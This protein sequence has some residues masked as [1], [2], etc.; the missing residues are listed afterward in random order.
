MKKSSKDVRIVRDLAKQV[1][2]IAGSPEMEASRKR[3]RDVNAL[4]RPDR[5][6]VW[7]KPVGAWKEL[8]P[9]TDLLCTDRGLRGIERAFR[10]VLIKRDIGD[11]S[12]VEPCF[13]VSPRIVTEPENNWGLEPRKH[14]PAEAGGAWQYD[15]PIKS[16]ADLEKLRMPKLTLDRA[17]TE[18]A[19]AAADELLGDI[20]P[21]KQTFGPENHRVLSA[22][23]GTA[24][25]DLRGL[26]QMMMDAA[27]EPELLHRLMAYL[28]DVNL[29]AMRQIEAMGILTP[30]NDGPMYCSDP[31]GKPAGGRAGYANCWCAANSQ[32]F[33]Q[34]SP[35]M[36]EEF[37]LAYQ[38]PIF[39]KY[40]LAGYG[41]CENLTRK[42]DGVLSIPN[43]R[44]FVCSAWTNLDT[45]L[46]KVGP[47][48]CIMWRQKASDV[49]FAEGDEAVRRPLD[50]GARKLRGRPY[51]IVLRELQT[52][53]GH[54]D[55]LHVWT[56]LA[57]E[58]AEKHA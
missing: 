56:R 32:E 46:S 55:R 31:I 34:F 33:D 26:E 39:A 30:N 47:Q 17:A 23:L 45:L 54:P 42:I 6:P 9:E 51:Q 1:A 13:E 48:Y 10:M 25:A 53:A 19:V 15:P 22:T 24:A 35:A 57:K 41:C 21:V 2:E 11:D 38:R 43:L 14:K 18:K 36:W 4:R 16:A 29:D 52:L 50:E 8:L 28:R 44:I 7:C 27:A 12:V 49:V 5:A 20:L 3:W 58:A 37:C 40:G